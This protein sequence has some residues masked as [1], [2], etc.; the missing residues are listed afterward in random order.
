[1]ISQKFRTGSCRLT[2]FRR[3]NGDWG[4]LHVHK[5]YSRSDTANSDNNQ[6]GFWTANLQRS[7][8]SD[9]CN[10]KDGKGVPVLLKHYLKL[11]GKLL[12]FS[13]AEAFSGVV[14][15]L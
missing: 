11:N 6:Q 1:M 12:S 5:L 10:E 7:F 4:F 3:K 9:L 8:F 13:I 14:D 2:G 15:G